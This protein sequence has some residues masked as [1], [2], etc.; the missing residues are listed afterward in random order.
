MALFCMRHPVDPARADSNLLQK[1]RS[2]SAALLVKCNDAYREFA[3]EFRDKS[4]WAP[5]VVSQQMMGWH[6]DLLCEI[7]PLS[8]FF[9]SETELGGDQYRVSQKEFEDAFRTWG[10]ERGVV[11]A[12][13][14]ELLESQHLDAACERKGIQQVLCARYGTGPSNQRF[15]QGIRLRERA[16][17]TMAD[18]Y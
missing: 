10:K 8:A 16:V 5:D 14:N 13:I 7:D 4:F 9:A 1:L 17:F 3:D 11:H 18:A 6:E 12:R 15:L 2:G